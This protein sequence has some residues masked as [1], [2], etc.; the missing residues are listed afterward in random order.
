V[1]HFKQVSASY[2]E[3]KELVGTIC[4]VNTNMY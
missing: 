1:Q 4:S 2:H 3:L